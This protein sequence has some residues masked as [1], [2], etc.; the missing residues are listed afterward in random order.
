M[1][2]D[3]KDQPRRDV[4][5][6]MIGSI[7][8]RPIAFV[9]TISTDGTL[10]LAPFSFFTGVTSQPPTI[11]FSPARRPADGTQKDTLNNIVA[12]GE[13]VV[14]VVT[15]AIARQMNEAATDFPPEIDEF[16]MTGL[17]PIPSQIVAPPRV[18]E[19]P[20]NMECKLHQV[21][22][23]GPEGPGGGALVIG[24]IVL[25]HVADELLR[26]GRI[27]TGALK[28]VGRLAGTEYTTLG[29]RF[30]MERK[31]YQP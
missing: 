24:E 17:T 7:L 9:S 11:C 4:Y 15:E 29:R 27:D 1:I 18:K 22:E 26:K 31:K 2:I 14:N 5:K 13:F 8:P 16:E 19:S 30:S 20:I 21:I 3:P 10:N 25:F 12:T 23:I 6:L 28:P